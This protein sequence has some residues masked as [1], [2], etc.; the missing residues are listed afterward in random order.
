MT[1]P[2][3]GKY[4]PK[5]EQHPAS[6]PSSYTK[7]LGERICFL[8]AT[9]ATSI[10]KLT[11]KFPELP[12][13]ETI[14]KWRIQ[15]PEFGAMFLEAK[16]DQ[17]ILYADETIDIADD[18]SRDLLDTDKGV[19][20]NSAAVARA[21]LRI[22]TRKWYAS[23]LAPRTFGEKSQTEIVLRRHEDILSELE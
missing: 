6:M 16:K 20:A 4:T 10:L 19:V 3:N 12:S 14:F 2:K 13:H 21:K 17:A 1:R 15:F 7:E 11:K 18:D 9:N 22:D 8:I 5:E 23:T